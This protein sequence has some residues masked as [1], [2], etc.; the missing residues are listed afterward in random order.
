ML[1]MNTP[2]KRTFYDWILESLSLLSLI[3]ALYPLLFYKKLGEGDIIPIHYNIAGE[4]DGWGNRSFLW[5]LPLIAFVI[6]IGFSFIERNYK[7]FN[8]PFKVSANN[9]ATVY[10]LGVRLMRHLKLFCMFIFTYINNSSYAIATG[11]GNGLNKY[12]MMPLVGAILI[13]SIV[14]YIKIQSFKE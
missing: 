10:R 9:L 5:I 6:Y 11:E 12:I 8:R 7:R 2:L 4:I 13:T 1:R 3:S 14:Y